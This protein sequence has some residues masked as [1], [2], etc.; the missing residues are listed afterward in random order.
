MAEHKQDTDK[1]P[2]GE[3]QEVSPRRVTTAQRLAGGVE[4]NP[5]ALVAGGLALGVIAGALLPRS[6]RE[7]DL[8]APVGT[9]LGGALT[10][11]VAAAREAGQ[12][13][14][15]G[16]GI[17]RDAA[18]DQVKTLVDGLLKAASTAGTA[19]AQAAVGKAAG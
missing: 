1:K 15:D 19:A 12:S 14:L 13:E 10:A 9:K 6:S 17:N 18:R 2:K 5:L 7:R 4:T 11:A 16:L 3:R 8:L